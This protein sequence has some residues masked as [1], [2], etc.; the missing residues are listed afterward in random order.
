MFA[1]A[2]TYLSMSGCRREY[3]LKH[4]E[5][6]DQ[7]D[8]KM[9]SADTSSKTVKFKA[10]CCDNCTTRLKN[11]DGDMN[12]EETLTDFSKDG[13]KLLSVVNLLNQRYGIGTYI[14]YLL[15]SVNIF[16]EFFWC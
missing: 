11:C 8:D 7:G 5:T 13:L 12:E 1:K 16:V 14:S 2:Q 15:G 4:F 3:L 9:C 6:D 10:N